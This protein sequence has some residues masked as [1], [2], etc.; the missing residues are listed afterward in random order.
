MK[1]LTKIILF[2]M[3][4]A[5]AGCKESTPTLN[6]Y[7]WGDF[8]K[9]ELINE[10]ETRYNCR[11]V[12][13]TYD[14]NEAM[15]AKLKSGA[16]GYDLIFPSGYI[17]Q[18]MEEQKMLHPLN[19]SLIPNS[20]NIDSKYLKALN[21]PVYENG[22]PY[23]ITFSGIAYRE[24]K[25]FN[26]NPSWKIFNRA[27]LKG[28]MTL[29]NDMR[30][31][32][33]AALKTFGFSI[34]T[35]N[36]NEIELAKTEVI[37]WKKN[38]AKFESEQYKNG[39]ASA[40]YLVVQGYSSDICQL[41]SDDDAI[42]LIL[43]KEGSVFSCDYVAIPKDALNLTLAHAFINFLLEPNVALANMEAN[44]YLS[45]NTPAIDLLSD[46]L[47][48]NPG[49]FPPSEFV[50]KSESIRDLGKNIRLYI[51]AWNAIKWSQ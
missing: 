21:E 51:D 34:N 36:V 50:E 15:Y 22:I 46:E 37:A 44:F 29:L 11:V 2:V 23:A 9:N 12:I 41:M 42:S 20:E 8:I 7:I 40:E 27:D 49:I 26:L 35:V 28:R 32:L 1:C 14:S 30:E 24:D 31:V 4:I 25:V 5:L 39:I 38:I 33:G 48:T 13:D 19:K 17:L 3:I 45:P 16:S 47:K 10:F 43:P 18:V 6:I